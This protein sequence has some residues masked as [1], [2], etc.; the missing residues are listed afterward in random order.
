MLDLKLTL[1][2]V[3]STE[4]RIAALTDTASGAARL[5][6]LQ[7]ARAGKGDSAGLDTDRSRLEEQKIR[8]AA[9]REPSS[10]W[11]RRCASCG[12]A[13]GV[14]CLPFG[15]PEKA[16]AFLEAA[17][18]PRPCPPAEERDDLK[19]LAAQRRAA[20]EQVALAD[21]H[22]VPDPTF[23]AGYLKDQFVISGNN[24]STVFVGVTVPLPLFDR[25][26]ADAQAARVNA[27]T[28]ARLREKLLAQRERERGAPRGPAQARP[29]AREADRGE[30]A[31]AGPPGRGEPGEGACWSARRCRT[32]SSPGARCRSCSA[33]NAD[34]DLAVFH[35]SIELDRILGRALA[36]PAEL[37]P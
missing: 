35:T 5:T 9:Q 34:V 33:D 32:S 13:A 8:G 36:M 30:G 11:R 27:E 10:T 25:G 18:A 19:A 4:V 28:A 37:S 23:R 20:E 6:A 17:D 16:Q 15:S 12:H 7:E 1:A 24:P 22:A 2:D 26:Q 21:A 3:A 29:G 31:A 14:P